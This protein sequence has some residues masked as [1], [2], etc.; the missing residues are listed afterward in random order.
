MKKLIFITLY[1]L[2][3][4]FYAQD[5]GTFKVTKKEFEKE[6]PKARR[7]ESGKI[8]VGYRSVLAGKSS[9]ETVRSHNLMSGLLWDLRNDN[10]YV[11]TVGLTGGYANPAVQYKGITL[12]LFAS[13]DYTLLLG[14]GEI[15]IPLE[16]CYKKLI[17]T[18][19][20]KDLNQYIITSGLE[21]PVPGYRRLRF[22]FLGSYIY[23]KNSIETF[24]GFYPSFSINYWFL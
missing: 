1:F 3:I 6:T 13:S 15:H 2:S 7:N 23:E 19:D 8:F 24:G 22:S 11:V 14:P 18:L 12:G 5:S 16:I 21:I 20:Y 9:P 4:S 17:N 10:R